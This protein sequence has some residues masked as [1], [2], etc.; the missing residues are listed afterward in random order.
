MGEDCAAP[1]SVE[2]EKL[3]EE[4]FE[5]VSEIESELCAQVTGNS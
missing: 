3:G 4:L 5:R 1:L 2:K